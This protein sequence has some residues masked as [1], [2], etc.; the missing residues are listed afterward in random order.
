LSTWRRRAVYAAEAVVPSLS[1]ND[2]V[3]MFQAKVLRYVAVPTHWGIRF[4]HVFK[5]TE[6]DCIPDHQ[7]SLGIQKSR[8][9]VEPMNF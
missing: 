4:Q 8:P 2:Q 9:V 6:G 7:L 5:L 3:G 1:K